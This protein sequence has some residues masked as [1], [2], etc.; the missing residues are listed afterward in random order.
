MGV[1]VGVGVSVG[2]GVGVGVRVSVAVGSRV[3]LGDG[4]A[5]RVGAGVTVGMGEEVAVGDGVGT[6]AQAAASAMS[7]MSVT[8]L[9][10]VVLRIR[11]ALL[12]RRVLGLEPS[13]A[14]GSDGTADNAENGT[15]QRAWCPHLEAPSSP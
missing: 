15:E 14:D 12:N 13:V 5:V 3:W 1:G 10:N 4:D 11:S 2:T 8:R 6:G 9:F 7:V